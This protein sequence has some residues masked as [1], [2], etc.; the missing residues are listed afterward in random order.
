MFGGMINSLSQKGMR[1][2]TVGRSFDMLIDDYIC[3]AWILGLGP[4]E[5][6]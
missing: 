1:N 4:V 3:H 5:D 2:G 6:F